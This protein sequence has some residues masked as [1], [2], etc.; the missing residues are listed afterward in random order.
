MEHTRWNVE[1]HTTESDGLMSRVQTDVYYSKDDIGKN[2][3]RKRTFYTVMVEQDVLAHTADEA[4]E[5]FREQGGLDHDK[6][7]KDITVT[8]KG[9]ET[10]VVDA[11]YS[12]SD[13]T[14]YMAKVVYNSDNEYAKEDGDVVLDPWSDET[15]PAEV[16]YSLKSIKDNV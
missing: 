12:F 4:D 3:Y 11:D 8:D 16:H 13:P 1:T 10:V 15:G 14:Q 2:L 6:I 9:V 5:L 7:G